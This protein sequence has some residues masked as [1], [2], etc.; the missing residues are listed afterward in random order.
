MY[1]RDVRTPDDV[2]RLG[3]RVFDDPQR[4]HNGRWA[5]GPADGPIGCT[6][7]DCAYNRWRYRQDDL[8]S[9]TEASTAWVYKNPYG[10]QDSVVIFLC[11]KHTGTLRSL[12]GRGVRGYGDYEQVE[13]ATVE[14]VA[15]DP[16]KYIDRHE[17][18]LVRRKRAADAAKAARIAETRDGVRTDFFEKDGYI[19]HHPVGIAPVDEYG[20]TYVVIGRDKV[21]PRDARRLAAL[22]VEKADAAEA[23]SRAAG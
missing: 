15:A 8:F 1:Y 18:E 21:R 5:A 9:V 11:R 23:E 13:F 6:A 22:L 20:L 19:S 17:V 3:V 16:G 14:E 4:P 10:K 2:L 12:K 7:A